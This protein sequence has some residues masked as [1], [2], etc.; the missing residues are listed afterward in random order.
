LFVFFGCVFIGL[1]TEDL[2]KKN[3]QPVKAVAQNMFLNTKFPFQ[4]IKDAF[5]EN[6][7]IVSLCYSEEHNLWVGICEE[8]K[9]SQSLS[10]G[11]HFPD[12][13]IKELGIYRYGYRD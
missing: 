11:A 1:F 2:K 8:S 7:G 3:I 5:K 4:D 12:S 13:K 6:K 9:Y 10:T